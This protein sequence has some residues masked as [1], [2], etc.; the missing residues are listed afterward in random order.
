MEGQ[1]TISKK[2]FLRLKIVEEKFDRLEL[3]GV[4]NWDWYGDS[5]NPAGQPSLDE[6][7]EREKLRIAA[8]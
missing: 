3:G 2:E 5:L 1:V 8:L 4:D 6:F 7:E